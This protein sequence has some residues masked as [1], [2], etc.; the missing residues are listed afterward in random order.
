MASE[1]EDGNNCLWVILSN[2]GGELSRHPARSGED[3]RKVAAELVMSVPYFDP[4][5]KIS[6]E[7][8]WTEQFESDP[9]GAGPC[10]YCKEQGR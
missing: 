1:F 10:P 3:A 6:F 8:G 5:D 7:E 4:G 9:H 2:E